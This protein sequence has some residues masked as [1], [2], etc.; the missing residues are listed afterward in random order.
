MSV[1]YGP[2]TSATW[3]LD[4]FTARQSRRGRSLQ[5]Y[6]D[7]SLR[8]DRPSRP[9][10]GAVTPRKV[11]LPDIQKARALHYSHQETIMPMEETP[12]NAFLTSASVEFCAPSAR[13]R[14]GECLPVAAKRY[15]ATKAFPEPSHLI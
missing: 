1:M 4:D 3:N 6:R 11:I 5:R 2:W 7:G 12:E 14:P 15:P 10:P 8:P 9:P 13:L